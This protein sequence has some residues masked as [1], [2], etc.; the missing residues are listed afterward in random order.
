MFKNNS[1]FFV[2]LL[3]GLISIRYA[4]CYSRAD[5]NVLSRI[6][7]PNNSR[8]CVFGKINHNN[9]TGSFNFTDPLCIDTNLRVFSCKGGLNLHF[10]KIFN[11]DNFMIQE[12]LTGKCLYRNNGSYFLSTCNSCLNDSFWNLTDKCLK[13]N[14]N[15][16]IGNL[17]CGQVSNKRIKRKFSRPKPMCALYYIEKNLKSSMHDII[18]PLGLRE[19]VENISRTSDSYKRYLHN[20][21][22]QFGMPKHCKLRRLLKKRRAVRRRC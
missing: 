8:M 19:T 14:I 16:A 15:D 6:L 3:F 18:K 17:L 11:C 2:T 4:Y 7:D 1:I 21:L 22:Y 12:Q 9:L 20:E 13:P 10:K 5:E